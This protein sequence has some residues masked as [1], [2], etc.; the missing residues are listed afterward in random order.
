MVPGAR[1]VGRRPRRQLRGL[2]ALQLRDPRRARAGALPRRRGAPLRHREQGGL[3]AAHRHCRHRGAP[4]DRQGPR[5]LQGGTGIPDTRIDRLRALLEEPL[6]VTAPTNVLYLTGFESSNAAVLVEQDR[7][8]LF[9]DFRYAER[10]RELEEW[11]SSRPSASSTATS[12]DSGHDRVRGRRRD[13][14]EPQGSGRDGRVPG[15]ASRPG[16]VARPSRNRASSTPSVRRPGSRTACTSA[17]PRSSSA[18][19][20]RK[21]SSGG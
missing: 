20:R 3:A 21:S 11:T 15:A 4:G 16:R 9:T 14:R 7:V 12:P 1:R 13:L 6:L 19:G 8:R 18:A 10:A 5:R 2:V 17:W